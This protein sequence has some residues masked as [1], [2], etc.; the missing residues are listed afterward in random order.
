MFYQKTQH[1][2]FTGIGLENL[3]QIFWSQKQFKTSEIIKKLSGKKKKRILVTNVIN[4]LKEF[5][6]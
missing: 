1:T 4:R 5:R 3:P 2:H 6:F